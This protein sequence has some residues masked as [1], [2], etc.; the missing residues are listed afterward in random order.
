M[1]TS[2]D[3]LLAW[4]ADRVGKPAGYFAPAV[5]LGSEADDHIRAAVIFNREMPFS[6]YCHIVTDGSKTWATPDF[7]YA[8]CH[9]PFIHLGKERVTVLVDEHNDVSN[10]FVLRMGFELESVMVRGGETGDMNVYRMFKQNCRWL[11]KG[12]VHVC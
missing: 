8:I 6:I 1:I 7:M 9:Y 4:A 10:E 3:H 2:G 12:E 5:A 11:E